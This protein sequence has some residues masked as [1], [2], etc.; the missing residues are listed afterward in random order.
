M[1]QFLSRRNLNKV[2][3]VSFIFENVTPSIRDIV[4][5]RD[6]ISLLHFFLFFV[7]VSHRVTA[8]NENCRLNSP[9]VYKFRLRFISKTSPYTDHTGVKLTINPK[10][11]RI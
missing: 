4:Q 9:A 11:E 3:H 5:R 6:N 8:M 1:R 7:Y 2:L 10:R